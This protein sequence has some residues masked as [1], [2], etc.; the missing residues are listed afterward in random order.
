MGTERVGVFGG[1]FDPIHIGHLIAAEEARIVCGLS[2]VVFMPAASPPHKQGRPI[3]PAE[4]RLTM[5]ELAIASHSRFSCSAM[6][7]ERAGPSYTVDT[8]AQLRAR[9]GEAVDIVFIIGLDSLLA[10]PTWRE[11]QRIIEM[12]RLA[13]VDREP[14][15]V[16]MA[17]L[18]AKVPG[19]AQRVDFIPIPLIAI[20]A[21]ELRERVRSGRSIKYQVPEAVEGY[22]YA[23]GLYAARES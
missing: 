22:I 10:L 1:T 15:E 12:A 18:E 2:R 8:L 20:A 6:E 3:T 11:P 4:H 23:Q 9:W 21:S 14:F 7:M 16:D 17:A 19:L 5:T 13:V